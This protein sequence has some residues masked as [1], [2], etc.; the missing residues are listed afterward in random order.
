[1]DHRKEI[2]RIIDQ[3]I[4]LNGPN[5]REIKRKLNEYKKELEEKG[6]SREEV[7]SLVW[8]K[9]NEIRNK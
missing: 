6:T 8:K 2:E 9:F 1:M 7:I 3:I 4:I 5:L